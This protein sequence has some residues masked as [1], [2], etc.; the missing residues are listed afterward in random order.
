M[1]NPAYNVAI[2]LQQL[3]NAYAHDPNPF[4]ESKDDL[5]SQ[6]LTLAAMLTGEMMQTNE[7]FR[8][9]WS[10]CPH[11]C[12]WWKDYCPVNCDSDSSE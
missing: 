5:A 8:E 12:G 2:L 6:L 7:D 11:G 1:E 4:G 10:L 3:A 9:E